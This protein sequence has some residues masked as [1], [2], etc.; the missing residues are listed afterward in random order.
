MEKDHVIDSLRA[1]VKRL[2]TDLEGIPRLVQGPPSRVRG[3]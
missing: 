1:D 2:E 3:L